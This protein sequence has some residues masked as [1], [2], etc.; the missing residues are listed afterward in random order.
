MFGLVVLAAKG[1]QVFQ[2]IVAALTEWPCVVTFQ[3]L[4]C[5]TLCAS[6]PISNEGQI[7]SSAVLGPSDSLAATVGAESMDHAPCFKRCAAFWV[8]TLSLHFTIPLAS[9]CEHEG[10]L[11]Y[12]FGSNIWVPRSLYHSLLALSLR[13]S[14]WLWPS[15]SLI[16]S[17]IIAQ[18]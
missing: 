2:A 8:L 12:A 17:Y 5:V 4:C 11:H 6:I 9:A 10:R 3:R 7:S 15:Y 18:P 16:Y 1:L 13:V 14:L